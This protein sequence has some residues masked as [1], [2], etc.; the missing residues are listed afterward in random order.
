MDERDTPMCRVVVVSVVA[1]LALVLPG[2]ATAGEI[3]SMLAEI[4]PW[5]DADTTRVLAYIGEQNART[6]ERILSSSY[7]ESTVDELGDILG[8]DYIGSPYIDN[9]GRIYFT[10]RI[11]GEQGALFYVDEPGGWPIQVTPNGWAEDGLNPGGTRLEPDGSYLY[12]MVMKHG[13]E[14]WD[15]YRFTPDGSHE[16]LLEDRGISFGTP[17]IIDDGSF[18]FSIDNSE[19]IWFA[20]YD[21]ASGVVDTLYTEPG[22]FYLIDHLGGKLLAVR[23]ISF[24]E[25]QLFEVDVESGETRD[26]TDVGLYWS[27]DYTEDGRIVTMCDAFSDDDEFLKIAILDPTKAIGT[28]GALTLLYDPKAEMDEAYFKRATGTIVA[29]LNRDGYSEL[30]RVDLDGSAETLPAPGVGIIGTVGVNDR[31]DIVFDF[32]SP[33][34]PPTAYLLA[35]GA[36]ELQQIGR[37]S[38]FGFDFSGVDVSVIRY[39]S[40]DGVM[41]PALLYIPEGATRDG[42]NPCIVDYHGGPPGQSRP[43]FQRNIAWALSKGICFIYPNVRGSTGYGPAWEKADNLEGRFQALE[44]AEAALDYIFDEGWSSPEKTAIWG[45]SY[46]GYTVNY[47]AVHAP[48]KFACGVSEVGGAD[49]DWVNQHTDQTFAAGWE[50]E[51]GELGSDLTH[52]LS[53]I[54]QADHVAR[55]ILVTA[56]YNDPRVD[57][58]GPRRFAMVLEGLGK[59]VWYFEDVEAG[60]GA[61]LKSSGVRD[62]SRKYAFTLDYIGK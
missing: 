36:S 41:I 55:P 29:V 54:Y 18:Y 57:P 11:T 53:P 58:S 3:E 45:A 7:W 6:E 32:N 34:D 52:S 38:T 42:S 19:Q 26:I 9:N 16:I 31:G 14:N 44:D 8:I 17:H 28:E 59:D 1:V 22:A 5:V 25:T 56:G 40:T 21:I 47:L 61:A 43:Y 35:A 23:L 20:K 33:S 39:P 4:D 30:V 46:G 49:I 60:H 50:R 13:D 2:M 24:S 12:K 62:L 51:M 37:V 15:I 10:M 27:G 48:E